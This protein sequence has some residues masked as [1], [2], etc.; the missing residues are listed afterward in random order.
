M[1]IFVTLDLMNFFFFKLLMVWILEKDFNLRGFSQLKKTNKTK[2]QH[3]PT[4]NKQ[5]NNL[6]ISPAPAGPAGLCCSPD[7][8]THR[9]DDFIQVH[10]CNVRADDKLRK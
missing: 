3:Q 6:H 4:A 10:R 5:K 2:T 9:K 7:S 1:S 8:A